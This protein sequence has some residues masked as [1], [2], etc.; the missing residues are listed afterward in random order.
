MEDKTIEVHV[1]EMDNKTNTLAVYQQDKAMVDMQIVTAKRYPRKLASCIENS[2][3]LA[4]L[5]EET[6]KEC[7]YNLLK[8]GKM[9]KGPSVVLAKIMAREFGNMRVENR[10]VGYDKTHVTCEATA[11]DLE[12]NYAIRTTIKKSLLTSLGGRVSEDMAVIIGNAGNAVALRNAVFAILPKQVVDKVYTAVREKIAGKLS[13]ENALTAA[14]AKMIE[15]VKNTYPS[16]A[17]TDEEI[18]SAFGKQSISHLTKDDIIDFAGIETAIKSGDISVESVFRPGMAQPKPKPED[19]SA[20]R[21]ELMIDSAKTKADLEKLEKN[22]TT[23]TLMKKYEE[24][25]KKFSN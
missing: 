23:P 14:R 6:A 13:D 16:Y 11:F 7:M 18:A 5:S 24:K 21:L 3:A 20:E 1:E 10:V 15:H 12:K 4:T 9:I 19:K 8:G 2:I 22:C 25:M 17:F